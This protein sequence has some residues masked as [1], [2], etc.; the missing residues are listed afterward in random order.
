MTGARIACLLGDVAVWRCAIERPPVGCLVVA[1]RCSPPIR[2][3]PRPRPAVEVV[4]GQTP[5]APPKGLPEF[6]M[7]GA[8]KG[9]K[10]SGSRNS[11]LIS[12]MQKPAVSAPASSMGAAAMAQVW[13]AIVVA[14]GGAVPG[15][16][17]QRHRRRGF[18]RLIVSASLQSARHH[19]AVR[20]LTQVPGHFRQQG[21]PFTPA[22]NRWV[23]DQRWAADGRA[24]VEQFVLHGGR[25]R[26][27]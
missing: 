9:R 3:N 26:S 4:A 20:P 19:G 5:S 25:R 18:H 10:P 16:E 2:S 6:Q 11:A 14:A 22:A 24:V 15:N 27:R 21:H 23:G 12:E 17:V 8:N 7:Y 13:E 1:L